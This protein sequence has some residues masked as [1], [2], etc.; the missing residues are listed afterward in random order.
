MRERDGLSALRG[1]G[2]S[3]L[4]VV[5]GVPLELLELSKSTRST[6]GR[7]QGCNSGKIVFWYENATLLRKAVAPI[8]EIGLISWQKIFESTQLSVG[9]GGVPTLQG[10]G[11]SSLSGS[12]AG[13][14][15]KLIDFCVTQL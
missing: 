13:S 9:R 11:G 10:E 12:E 5:A 14:Y 7:S 8:A 6:Y 4:T 1:K 3:P 15:F 2:A